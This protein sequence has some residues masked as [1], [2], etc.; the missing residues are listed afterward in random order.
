MSNQS[1]L[2]LLDRNGKRR[3]FDVP[4]GWKHKSEGAASR[5]D[6]W[7]RWGDESWQ[8]IGEHAFLHSDVGL[9]QAV[10]TRDLDI[11]HGIGSM[12]P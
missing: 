10:I 6:R 2:A 11:D 8:P 1:K 7:W 9:L 12:H 5:G 3:E 4:A